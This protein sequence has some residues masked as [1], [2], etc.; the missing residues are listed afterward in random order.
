[1]ASVRERVESLV[2]AIK[3]CR[4]PFLLPGDAGSL[5][6]GV[7]DWQPDYGRLREVLM[8]LLLAM[9]FTHFIGMI[10]PYSY[11]YTDAQYEVVDRTDIAGSP[12]FILESNAQLSSH[13]VVL[14]NESPTAENGSW[15]ARSINYTV[16]VYSPYG[17]F[18]RS[19][20][21]QSD[22]VKLYLRQ[23]G[24]QYNT[25]MIIPLP[26]FSRV[27]FIAKF[28]CLHGS[29]DFVLEIRFEDLLTYSVT[30]E[31]TYRDHI[32][33][34]EGEEGTLTFEVPLALL[35]T[36]YEVLSTR[37]AIDIEIATTTE[38]TVNVKPLVV[39]A[40]SADSLVPVIV[41]MR[42]TDNESLFELHGG[43]WRSRY[44]ALIV[45]RTDRTE[46]P[47]ILA[48]R[49]SNDT[50]YLA[51]GEYSVV[52]GWSRGWYFYSEE[53]DITLESTV[54]FNMSLAEDMMYKAAILLPSTRIHVVVE[55]NLLV[56]QY[57]VLTWDYDTLYWEWLMLGPIPDTFTLPPT[58]E[59]IGIDFRSRGYSPYYEYIGNGYGSHVV[60]NEQEVAT[61]LVTFP[62][63]QVLGLAVDYM[64]LVQ[65]LL[66][67]LTY[68]VFVLS[69]RRSQ[70]DDESAPWYQ[71]PRL[72]PAMLLGLSIF[73]PWF[74]SVENYYG[75]WPVDVYSE[76]RL[77]ILWILKWTHTGLSVP[78]SLG[79]PGGALFIP[80]LV[81]FWA[82]FTYI[83]VRIG[84][85]GRWDLQKW[86]LRALVWLALLGLVSIVF[87]LYLG[88]RVGLGA[89]LVI[90]AL[91]FWLIQYVM[92]G[93]RWD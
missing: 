9:L 44:P 53:Y 55:P 76:L 60:T 58:L 71:D 89:V 3:A 29:A 6:K 45:V 91:P 51:P 33:L 1:M 4:I 83:V 24:V 64:G 40:S 85:T 77:P 52:S 82:P 28:Q 90:C 56:S 22:G 62:V 47:R 78:A 17:F 49:C 5:R 87:G 21:D 13:E 2:A 20:P 93:R 81:L 23:E 31:L 15:R 86:D 75:I 11:T 63:I 19:P 73:F 32:S 27:V 25:H 67:A 8:V 46:K 42:S 26:D 41:D 7:V 88:F 12:G 61:V 74:T 35:S 57:E 84:K 70:P 72:G 36:F 69:L 16:P 30:D 50:V 66:L 10:P 79:D 39:T 68:A 43:V 34:S 92:R 14:L 59:A 54:E 18:V 37:A 48:P 65:S 38:A 80:V